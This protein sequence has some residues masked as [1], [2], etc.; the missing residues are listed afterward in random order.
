MERAPS[1]R[2]PGRFTRVLAVIGRGALLMAGGA[3]VMWSGALPPLPSSR[4]DDPHPSG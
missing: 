4:E 2:R 3:G 1:A